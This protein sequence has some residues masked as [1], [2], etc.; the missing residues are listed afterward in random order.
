[1]GELHQPLTGYSFFTYLNFLAMGVVSQS[2]SYLALNYALGYLLASVV[3]P[4]MLGQPVVK[5]IRAGPL[6]GETLSLWQVLGGLAVLAGVY[7]VP[8]SRKGKRGNP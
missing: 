2:F 8:C 4:T 5:A 1:V 6:L 3:A 7:A